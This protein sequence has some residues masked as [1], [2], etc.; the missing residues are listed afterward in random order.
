MVRGAGPGVGAGDASRLQIKDNAGRQLSITDA[1]LGHFGH[2]KTE[3]MN[4]WVSCFFFMNGPH[5]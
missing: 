3:F 4:I 1:I 5:F 2:L